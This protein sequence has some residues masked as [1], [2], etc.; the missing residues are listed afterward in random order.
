MKIRKIIEYEKNID[1]VNLFWVAS[2]FEKSTY[3]HKF[4]YN[5]SWIRATSETNSD[6]QFN[7]LCS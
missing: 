1:V 4:A 5:F 6:S 3:A 2:I 7:D